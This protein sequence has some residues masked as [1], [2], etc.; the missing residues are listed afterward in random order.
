MLFSEAVGSARSLLRFPLPT[1]LVSAELP[2]EL[3]SA[4]LGTHELGLGKWNLRAEGVVE[5][6]PCI[7]PCFLCV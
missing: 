6:L 1:E 4:E 2:T 7:G 5:H 3:V